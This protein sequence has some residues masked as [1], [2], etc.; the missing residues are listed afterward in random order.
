MKEAK[1]G[2]KPWINKSI[3][4]ISQLLEIILAKT[5][6]LTLVPNQAMNHDHPSYSN[7]TSSLII[8]SMLV[9]FFSPSLQVNLKRTINVEIYNENTRKDQ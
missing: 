4:V 9:Y 5:L 7:K 8:T 3:P 6:I 2:Q 1:T